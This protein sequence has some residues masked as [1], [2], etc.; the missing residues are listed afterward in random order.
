MTA[1]NL[2]EAGTTE[3]QG[4]EGRSEVDRGEPRTRGYSP[5]LTCCLWKMGVLQTKKEP[6]SSLLASQDSLLSRGRHGEV[7]LLL[8]RLNESELLSASE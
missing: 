6:T 4:R 5:P 3:K 7:L 1:H 8:S 2:R